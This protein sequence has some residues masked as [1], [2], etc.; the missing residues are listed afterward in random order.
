MKED[1]PMNKGSC[2]YPSLKFPNAACSVDIG[3]SEETS[4]RC[5]I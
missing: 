5:D 4:W 2:K 1:K 3:V